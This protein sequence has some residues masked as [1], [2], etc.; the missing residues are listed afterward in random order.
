MSARILAGLLASTV[1]AAV[2][3]APG[4]EPRPGPHLR[5][6]V[7]PCTNIERTFRKLHPLLTYL[8]SATG[9]T[10]TL[11][12]P[13]DLPEFE[14]SAANGQLDFALQDPHTYRQL[15]SLFDDASLLQTRALDATTRQSAVVVVR[16]DSGVSDL[17]GLR[18]KTV[19][20]GPLASSSKWVAARLL[21]EA[22][23]LRVDRDLKRVNGGCC[24]DIA[25]AVSVKAVDAGVIC[26][27]F[28]GLHSARQKDLGVDPSS[29]TVIG[30]TPAFP[31]RI[32]AA[33][34]GV[35]PDAIAAIT[36]ALLH[37]DPAD[38]AHAR[39]LASAEMRGFQRTTR[40]EYLERLADPAPRGR[41]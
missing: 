24:E 35:P 15:S 29:L 17:A 7:L 34:R 31:T 28:L 41:R 38:P 14:T 1:L 32:F 19:M 18:G 10:V 21:F 33:R 4:A 20:F 40:A 11:S 2:P 26:D 9:L 16:R 37:L 13:G 23:G 6:A 12:V 30:R 3:L 39:I 5:L 36:R 27:H 25:F 8:K 22:R